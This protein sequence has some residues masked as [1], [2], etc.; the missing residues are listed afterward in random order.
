M[1][2]WCATALL[3]LLIAANP[4]APAG[5]ERREEEEEFG[6]GRGLF[7]L[8]KS[9]QVV[10]TEAGE[11]KVVKGFGWKGGPSPMHLGFISMEPNSLYVPQYMDSSLILFVRR[12]EAKVGWIYKDRLVEKQLKIGDIYRIPAG[13]TFY[14]ANT[15]RGQRLQMISSID[16]SES[17]GYGSFF[18]SGGSNPTS[19]LAGFDSHT[20]ATAFNRPHRLHQGRG[21]RAREEVNL[22]DAGDP[23]WGRGKGKQRW[24]GGKNMRMAEAPE[25][26]PVEERTRTPR[27]C[28]HAYNLY[29][30]T[31]DFK[32]DYGWS[33]AVGEDDYAPLKH[34]R[35][36]VFL[37]NLTAGAMMAPHINPTAAEY[38]VV[39]SGAGSVQ[40]VFPNGSL[41]MNAEVAEGDVF[42][43][44]RYFPFCQ[45]ASRSGSMEFFGF[46]TS[47]RKNR[48]QFL[49]GA[50][51]VLRAMMGPELAAAFAAGEDHL[52]KIAEAQGESTILPPWPRSERSPELWSQ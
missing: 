16:T 31:P 33:I 32:N 30:R 46:T 29:Q 5:N 37:V 7:L 9:K 10:K 24:G 18:I 34:A 41:A 15:G 45:V 14:I 23:N 19:V 20:L 44:P 27:R 42:W 25:L 50:G 26:R 48:P 1:T 49:V 11:V 28:P 38:G 3:M 6:G 47:A 39:L 40:V 43:V 51:S 8:E 22:H 36:G 21:L 52:R 17:L 2:A 13:S 4:A 12:G 35:A